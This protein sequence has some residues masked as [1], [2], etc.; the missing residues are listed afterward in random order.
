MT[1][2]SIRLK[3]YSGNRIK[4]VSATEQMIQL[5]DETLDPGPH[6][7]RTDENGFI[8]T[9]NLETRASEPVIV[10]IGGSFVESSMS[11]ETDRFASVLERLLRDAGY[12]YRI[13][14]AGYSGMTTLHQLHVVTAKLAGIIPRG[15]HIIHFIGQSDENAL[16]T[17]GSYWSPSP[18]L[19]PV[20]PAISSG[21]RE[22]DPIQTLTSLIELLIFAS[23]KMGFIPS[24]VGSPFRNGD[25]S[26]DPVL[27]MKYRRNRQ[28]YKDSTTM[29]KN[30][31][32]C[33]EKISENNSVAF[34]NAQ[35]SLAA[36]PEYFY[37][38]MHLNS[39]GQK[40]FAMIMKRWIIDWLQ[41]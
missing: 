18:T 27:R 8:S 1:K 12:R 11:A 10:L 28:S 33:A 9:G 22:N 35:K 16:R 26:W 5:S 2:Q 14:N 6:R 23:E 19:T 7:L 38:L 17:Q 40:E 41:K 21:L 37:D 20:E 34:L 39:L 36:N 4:T 24:I 25:F 13:L 15:S 29:R 30:I 3:S 31:I 32:D